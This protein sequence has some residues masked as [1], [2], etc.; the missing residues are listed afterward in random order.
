MIEKHEKAIEILT[1]LK[2]HKVGLEQ[3][4]EHNANNPV[5]DWTV[6]QIQAQ[7]DLIL[8]TKKDYLIVLHELN[9]MTV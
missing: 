2:V 7:K 1:L 4:I 6:Y 8:K 3:M 5:F 9:M